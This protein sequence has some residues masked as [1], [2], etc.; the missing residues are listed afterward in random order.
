MLD[1]L[2]KNRPEVIQF[3]EDRDGGGEALTIEALPVEP[4]PVPMGKQIIDLAERLKVRIFLSEPSMRG[5]M[6]IETDWDI[7]LEIPEASK[8]MIL[9]PDNY[10][11]RQRKQVPSA[12]A[13]QITS[14]KREIMAYLRAPYMPAPPADEPD[15]AKRSIWDR[16][17][18]PDSLL[19][20]A[21][22]NQRRVHAL[23]YGD[24]ASDA[25][26]ER[27]VAQL[28]NVLPLVLTASLPRTAQKEQQ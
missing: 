9:P 6:K 4:P 11:G 14:Y 2:A 7:P 20:N 19:P 16:M 1:L 27:R 25:A 8:D 18:H 23:L 21:R 15:P 28:N 5:T 22:D 3:V 10:V 12:L 24:G 26:T 13:A 17:A